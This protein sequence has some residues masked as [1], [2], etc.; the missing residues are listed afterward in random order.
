[1]DL[2]QESVNYVRDNQEKFL[3]ALSTHIRLSVYALV[4]AVLIFIP[5]GVIA[6]R[7]RG[8]PG[9]IGL[10][11]AARVVPSISVLFLLY[12]YRREIGKLFPFW[13]P[14]FSLALIALTL[15][16]GPPIIINTDA[17]LRDVAAPVLES[18]KGLGMT[19]AQV[20]AK[21][22]APLALPV[23]IA[24]I[25]TAAVEI[26]ASATFA[27]FIGVGGLGRFITSGITLYDFSLLLVGAIP[28]TLLALGAELSL[29][30]LQRLVSRPA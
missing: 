12:P 5:L 18:A 14:S 1:L 30:G 20:F 4:L 29:A 10:V 27:A 16:A 22:Q 19:S 23:I 26:V 8:G 21:V 7:W 24:G 6:S 9:L 2:L 28:V 25:R 13:N 11:A 3:D 17:G 15:L